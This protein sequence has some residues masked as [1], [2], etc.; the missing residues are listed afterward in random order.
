MR[1]LLLL[2][3]SVI[4]A[5]S[6]KAATFSSGWSAD[7]EFYEITT[8]GTYTASDYA[9]DTYTY[10][11]FKYTPTSNVV[12]NA[13]Y[14]GGSVALYGFYSA[15]DTTPS[16]LRAGR[17]YD[18]DNYSYVNYY[19]L[20]ADS[21]YYVRFYNYYTTSTFTLTDATSLFTSPGSGTTES[22][23]VALEEGKIYLLGKSNVSSYDYAWAYATYTATEDGVLVINTGTWLYNY[24]I[25]VTCSDGTE[26]TIDSD[27]SS[28]GYAASLTV[29]SGK[30]YSLSFQSS[31]IPYV[32]IE[33]THPTEGDLALPFTIYSGTNTIPAAAGTYWYKY[34]NG[35]TT[36]YATLVSDST[37]SR[38]TSSYANVYS[39]YYGASSGYSYYIDATS[40]PGHYTLEYELYYTDND[41]Y[42]EIIKAEATDAD[43]TFT[44]STRDYA[45]GETEDNPIEITSWPYSGTTLTSNGVTY[46]TFTVPEGDD[47]ILEV[48]RTNEAESSYSYVYVYAVN[49]W[50]GSS[51]SSS[52]SM[53]VSAGE[54]Y[55]IYWYAYNESSPIT[56]TAN[57]REAAQGDVITNP[58]VAKTGANVLASSGTVYYI[59]SVETGGKFTLDVSGT[60]I[61]A[62][63]PK[64]TGTY[65]GSYSA[66]LS[67]S[68]YTMEV[69]D[70]TDYLIKIMDA[71]E[72]DTFTIALG[73]YAEGES[74]GTAIDVTP[75]DSTTY[76]ISSSTPN[77]V[78]LQ[79][80]VQSDCILQMQCSLDYSYYNSVYYYKPS[81][82]STYSLRTYL[83]GAYTYFV[84][85]AAKAG[86]TYYVYLDIDEDVDA[87]GQTVTFTEREYG[88]GES[89]ETAYELTV[90]QTDTLNLTYTPSVMPKWAKVKLGVG[91][92]SISTGTSYLQ[93]YW[94]QGE[95]AALENTVDG[96][97]CD[98]DWGTVTYPD[99]TTANGYL[100]TSTIEEEGWYY[101]YLSM[102][103]SST[104]NITVMGTEASADDE[105][106]TSTVTVSDEILI[107]ADATYSAN[108]VLTSDNCT[109][110]LGNDTWTNKGANS[111]AG[112]PYTAYIAGTSNPKGDGYATT[113]SP[114]NYTV[115]DSGA[116]V[117]VTPSVDG[118]IEAGLIV[119]S[120]KSFYVVK[121][122]TGE[123]VDPS[124]LTIEDGS[125]N[126][127]ELSDTYTL[128]SKLYGT[129]TFD[130]EAEESYYIFCTGSKISFYGVVFTYEEATEDTDDT[131][132]S[133]DTGDDSGDTGDDSGDTGDDSGDTGDD[134]GDT[135][136]D[137]GDTGDDSGDDTDTGING[138]K[139]DANGNYT[140]YSIS[141]MRVMTTGTG[142]DLRT[143]PAGIYVINGKKVAIIK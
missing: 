59:Y 102:G 121:G 28:D 108:Q 54:T 32:W 26:S 141:G 143:L 45:A 60:D 125:G 78:W 88:E 43:E 101:M 64:G 79:Y 89:V 97:Y 12:I 100:W 13:T 6:A 48:T 67:N 17:Y 36:G 94:Y 105:E 131:D 52:L 111:D 30:T 124:L 98:G 41:W 77:P 91:D 33:L 62:S 137:S 110:T 112:E 92:V 142:S 73:E 81:S 11:W 68:V 57:L 117:I 129:V 34:N 7:Y 19:V 40:D 85:V 38:S 127:L 15:D 120:G 126:T 96:N 93:F 47:M 83:N 23:A 115:P 75:L 76:T 82:T 119:N 139:A 87:T 66:T 136:D 14:S 50:S 4:L 122:S 116:Y 86:E 113:Y 29:E 35:D 69:E 130:A 63:F 39:S 18:S 20:E 114:T 24:A 133:G 95:E 21:T 27:S 37:I 106:E 90:N 5:V 107:D 70:S 9:S 65:D 140:V 58:L 53:T 138:I 104:Y 46:Y 99:S 135:G 55:I 25:Y 44:F 72:G 103:Y 74:K 134:S 128:S 56:F 2:A 22:D 61:S 8:L 118:T 3:F 49:S 71:V 42:I 1:K 16:S 123:M 31:Y 10:T 109:V 132:D 80:T 84:E 51:S